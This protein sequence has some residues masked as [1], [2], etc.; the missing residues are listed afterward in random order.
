MK[1]TNTKFIVK[2]HVQGVGFRYFVYRKAIELGLRGY[3]KN[4]YDGSVEVVA[5]GNEKSVNELYSLLQK[6]PSRSLVSSVEI[7]NTDYTEKYSGFE[8]R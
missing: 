7:D 6:G 4:L 1:K 2:G 3:A 8:I 5:G